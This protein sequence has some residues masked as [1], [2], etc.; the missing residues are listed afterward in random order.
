[1]RG[2]AGASAALLLLAG[3]PVRSPSPASATAA[4]APTPAVP[5]IDQWSERF[6]GGRQ[7][8]DATGLDGLLEAIRGQRPDDY[9][10][11]S[12]GYLHARVKLE[13][14]DA[15]AARAG[16]QAF[17]VPG[18]PLRE[19]A[20][21]WH[22]QAA[23]GGGQAEV[24]RQDRWA[25][26][27]DHP[28]SPYHGAAVRELARGLAAQ[29]D[30][31]GLES[32]LQ[33]LPDAAGSPPRRY[34]QA[35]LVEARL[36]KGDEAG[37]VAEGLRLLRD[38]SNDDAAERIGGD[39][40]RKELRARL[41]AEDLMLL[42]ETLRAHR[43]F[44][45]ALGLLETAAAALPA[46][47]SDLLFAIGRTRFGSEDYAGAE[48]TY[49][50]GAAATTDA[51]EVGQFLYHAARAAL[52]MGADARAEAHLTR[53]AAALRPVRTARSRR[54]RGAPTRL[55]LVLVQ[56]LRLRLGQKRMAEAAADLALIQRQFPRSETAFDATV[57]YAVAL[58]AQGRPREALQALARAKH[59]RDAESVAET[60]YWEGRALERIDPPRAVAAYLRV[61]RTGGAAPFVG[62]ARQRLGGPL[63]ERSRVDAA[64]LER[65]AQTLQAAGQ[66]EAARRALTDA[67]LLSME[68]EASAR[69]AALG[70]LY[71]SLPAYARALDLQPLPF[72]R[73]P[74]PEPSPPAGVAG[75]SAPASTSPS[76]FSGN[77]TDLLLALGL[78]DDAGEGLVRRYP[79]EPPASA[80]A[81]A[82]GLHRAGYP[83]GAI[84][85]AEAARRGLP[86]DVPPALLPLLLRERL[87]PRY[88][89]EAI[90][91]DAARFGADERLVLSIMREESRFDTRARS[92]A[93]ARGLLQLIIGT[94][95]E[96][97]REVGLQQVQPEDLYDPRTVIPIG[98][99]YLA[100]LQREFDG[101]AMKAAAAYNAGPPQVH[102][103]TRL[104]PGPGDDVFYSTINFGETRAYVAK[105][106]QSYERYAG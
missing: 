72:P 69:R 58:V 88:Y 8:G 82:E 50:A 102:L 61:L 57:A 10:R 1:M 21:H 97:G 36:G 52:L 96:V 87:Y 93:A 30:V 92:L 12:L 40:D 16:L 37:A 68:P 94:A 55:A 60:A 74:L 100:D 18:H 81:R 86:E 28:N 44:D 13:A 4:A 76:G 64:R 63:R 65:E 34:V 84:R 80:L 78:F 45:R 11:Y 62:F 70:G 27:V 20:L 24:A 6:V 67:L 91:E 53:A 95:R 56:R 26:A 43:Q 48:K 103:W 83:R 104:A 98:A 99:K 7:P 25:L 3:S 15:E 5:P 49:L 79:L 19:L 54:G 29:R 32:L 38:R 42:G 47:R 35:S 59:R 89:Q 71:R 66:I 41:S 101:N 2:L 17:I 106:L 31:A 39:L 73:L 90:R 77:P 9:A 75:A 105:V 22:S 23:A 51:E 85:A 33:R 46:R 14:G